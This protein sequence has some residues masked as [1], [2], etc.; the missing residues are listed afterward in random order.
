MPP[1]FTPESYLEKLCLEAAV[2]RYGSVTPAVRA[3]LDEEFRLI[4]K[5][6]LAGFLLM[7][8]EV[9]NLGREVMLAQGL[10]DPS[11][12]VEEDP[13]R[14]RTR[15]LGG[16]AGRLSHRPLAHRPA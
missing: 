1:G 5:Y 12:T 4:N 16:P 11:L 10:S 14:E 7:Y 3:R 8:H 2:R 15:L 6:H 13:R 9:I